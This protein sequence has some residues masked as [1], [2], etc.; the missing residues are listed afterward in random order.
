[1]GK[2]NKVRPVGLFNINTKAVINTPQFMKVAH[3]F[4]TKWM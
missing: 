3:W 2:L 1:M 4:E